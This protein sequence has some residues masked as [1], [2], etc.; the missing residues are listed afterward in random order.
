MG[1]SHKYEGSPVPTSSE[2][3]LANFIRATCGSVWTLE[4]LLILTRHP[5]RAWSETEL[6]SALRASELIVTRALDE[7]TVA[8]FVA[9][10]PDRRVRYSPPSAKQAEMVMLVDR[11]YAR[12]PDKVRRIIATARASALEAFADAFRIRKGPE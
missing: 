5:D 2:Q 7:L 4:L 10:G 11:F 12:A 8:G 1:S 3:T 9:A 6:V